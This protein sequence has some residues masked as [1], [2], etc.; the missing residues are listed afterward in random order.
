MLLLFS[1]WTSNGLN[2][3]LSMNINQTL[4]SLSKRI[5]EIFSEQDI[6]SDIMERS[7]LV[8][9]CVRVNCVN[10]WSKHVPDYFLQGTL[11]RNNEC[12]YLIKPK[13]SSNVFIVQEE[14][15]A[16][17]LS[18]WSITNSIS[19]VDINIR[20]NH[21]SSFK[22]IKEIDFELIFFIHVIYFLLITSSL[23]REKNNNVTI[24]EENSSLSISWW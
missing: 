14:I 2:V 5:R 10:K 9:W 15:S 21:V 1:A 18:V 7:I 13:L 11:A 8:I 24:S 6:S 20:S 19:P 16:C 3:V 12:E 23:R 22:P 4:A 17:R